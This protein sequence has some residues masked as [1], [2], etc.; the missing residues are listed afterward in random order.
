MRFCS[1]DRVERALKG[2]SVAVVGS[3]PGVL[4]N[5]AGFVDS[6]D[7]VV[8]VNNYKTS[9]E[10]GFRTDV[11]YSFFGSSIRKT[12]AQL[13]ADGV[14][15]CVCKCP[16]AKVMESPWHFARRRMNGVDF[17]YI[18]VARKSWWFCDTY[19]PKTEEFLAD[20]KRLGAH[21]PTTGFSALLTVLRA[22]AA[23]VYVTGF[24][25]FKSRIHN[26]NE[27][28]RPGNPSDPIGHDPEGELSAL[29]EL[30]GAHRMTFD[31]AL[32]AIVKGLK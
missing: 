21:V 26:V 28:W 22:G 16:D 15:L 27:R 4:Q 5:P 13:K 19:V 30:S 12:P 9:Q 32:A 11:F 6:H 18:Y 24:D 7:V 2:R 31:P 10:A 25:F 29:I 17:R 14:T 1:W 20:F 3:G 23:S 8:R